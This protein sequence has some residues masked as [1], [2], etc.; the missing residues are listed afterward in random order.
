MN[1]HVNVWEECALRKRLCTFKPWSPSLYRNT[2]WWC[3]TR[4]KLMF[5]KCNKN[6]DR[7][8]TSAGEQLSRV[9]STQ[10]NNDKNA[11]LHVLFLTFLNS[12]K[13]RGLDCGGPAARVRCG[14]PACDL[15]R[16][17]SRGSQVRKAGGGPKEG[18]RSGGRNCRCASWRQLHHF[19][20]ILTGTLTFLLFHLEIA[21][22]LYQ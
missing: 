2:L 3:W 20:Q 16:G 10:D 12:Y 18:P 19:I 13:S 5:C 11:Y 7:N 8:Q 14:S 9:L 22:V 15:R 21:I 17:V 4:Q 1:N 6:W